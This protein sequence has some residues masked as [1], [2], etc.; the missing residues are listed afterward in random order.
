MRLNRSIFRF[1]VVI[2]AAC[3]VAACNTNPLIVEIT[4]CPAVGFVRYANSM[5]AFAPGATPV[6]SQVSHKATLSSLDVD[7]QDKGEGIRTFV[8]FT[9]TA[10]GGPALQG[11]NI[12]VPYFLVVAREGD[13]LQSKSIYSVDIPLNGPNSRSRTRE[14]V[15]FVIPT[16]RMADDYV[17]EVLIGFELSDDEARYNLES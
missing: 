2:A 14:R 6:A 5:T 17:Y 8:E 9:I 12:N 10:E 13:D 11:S 4:D 7:C 16:N 1:F 3:G 15:E